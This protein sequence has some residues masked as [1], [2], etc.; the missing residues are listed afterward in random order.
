[1]EILG[2]E[3]RTSIFKRCN[4][5]KAL[6][7]RVDVGIFWTNNL[8][9]KAKLEVI[10]T[11]GFYSSVNLLY[12]FFSF[13]FVIWMDYSAVHKKSSRRLFCLSWSY[14][15]LSHIL[16][17]NCSSCIIPWGLR[18]SQKNAGGCSLCFDELSWLC[19]D[20]CEGVTRFLLGER[21]KEECIT[22]PEGKLT[23]FLKWKT[24]TVLSFAVDGWM[25]E[26]AF[27]YNLHVKEKKN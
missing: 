20:L 6:W 25:D 16:A 24:W 3:T 22:R 2:T 17:D 1:M 14:R 18:D 4:P 12:L 19:V 10:R 8:R 15:E 23:S 21:M 5:I 27:L 7:K 9:F 26:C 11:T 13:H